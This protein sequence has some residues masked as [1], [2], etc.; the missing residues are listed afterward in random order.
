MGKW[1]AYSKVA[2]I[3]KEDVDLDYLR[4]GGTSL[5]K[6]G[7]E[8]LDTRR[9]LFLNRS[10]DQVALRIGRKLTGTVD[11]GWGLDSVGLYQPIISAAL[12]DSVK[13]GR[14]DIMV[15]YVGSS[16]Y[17]CLVSPDDGK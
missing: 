4:N 3:G 8:L 16:S 1:Q 12:M 5:L 7:L 9:S 15:T 13:R 17:G 2:H 11:A 14:N 6:N 10:F